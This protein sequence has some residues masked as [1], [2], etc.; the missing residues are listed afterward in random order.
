MKKNV[1]KAK[2]SEKTLD[3]SGKQGYDLEGL[4]KNL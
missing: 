4:I 2:K 3:P 1:K